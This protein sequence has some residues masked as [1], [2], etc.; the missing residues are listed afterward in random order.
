MAAGTEEGH[1]RARLG[2]ARSES[3]KTVGGGVGWGAEGMGVAAQLQLP[4]TSPW[5]AAGPGQQGPGPWGSTRSRTPLRGY[6]WT[7]PL[8]LRLRPGRRR[9]LPPPLPPRTK[10]P[11]PDSP[12]IC[13]I[14]KP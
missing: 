8:R 4:E 1:G 7:V 12:P 2:W 3:R 11:H 10:P 9:P 5:L 14:W 13:L 6:Q